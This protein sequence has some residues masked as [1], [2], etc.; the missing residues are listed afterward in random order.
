MHQKL[1]NKSELN[2]H[3]TCKKWQRKSFVLGRSYYRSSKASLCLLR[4][5]DRIPEASDSPP[6]RTVLET[7]RNS[8]TSISE[9]RDSELNSVP[10]LLIWRCRNPP[11]LSLLRFRFKI[12]IGKRVMRIYFLPQYFLNFLR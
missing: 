10:P 9:F 7:F 5:E 11:C 2:L 3:M 4:W 1:N 6:N 8:Q 12:P